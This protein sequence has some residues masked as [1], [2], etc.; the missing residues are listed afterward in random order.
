MMP[1]SKPTVGYVLPWPGIGGGEIATLRLARAIEEDGRFR[2]IAL[3]YGA[4]SDVARAF[5]R[6]SIATVPYEAPEFAYRHLRSYIRHTWTMAREIRRLAIDV[7]H[8]SDLMGLFHAGPAARLAGRPVVCHVR[9]NFPQREMPLHHK[10]PIASANRFVFVSHATWRNFDGIFRVPAHRG[11]VVYDWVPPPDGDS[12]DARRRVRAELGLADDAFVFGMVARVAPPKDFET[13]IAATANLVREHDRVRLVLI[14]DYAGSAEVIEYRRQLCARAR[15]LGVDR[16][17]V[18]TG[19]RR[20]VPAALDAVDAVV[21]ST[22]SEGFP[23]TILEALGRNRPV[24]ATRVGGVPEIIED[25]DT[26]LLH[27][28]RDIAGL[29][30]AMARLVDDPAFAARLALRGRAAAANR[31]TRERAVAAVS[32]SY[33]QLIGAQAGAREVG[34]QALSKV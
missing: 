17:I 16:H 13:L 33:A 23:L 20:D 15:T 4:G 24:I 7:V 10:A 5:A 9:S 26:G 1:R 3:C 18:W 32:A 11:S 28:P 12:L 31:F 30:A 21:L 14:G 6:A 27:E 29:A 2:P 34:A 25:G 19:F 8:C 22:L